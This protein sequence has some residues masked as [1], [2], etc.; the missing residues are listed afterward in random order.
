MTRNRNNTRPPAFLCLCASVVQICLA[1]LTWEAPIIYAMIEILLDLPSVGVLVVPCFHHRRVGRQFER[2]HRSVPYEK[3]LLWPNALRQL[4][5][6]PSTG[7][8]IYLSS[9]IL[10]AR[11]LPDMRTVVLNH[12]ICCRVGDGTGV[13]RVI[14][15]GSGRKRPPLARTICGALDDSQRRR[16]RLR[17]ACAL[18]VLIVASVCVCPEPRIPLSLTMTAQSSA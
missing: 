7:T 1:P 12:C 2:L 9:A 13:C 3:S 16:A 11:P 14:L 17:V 5:T 8:I 15:A 10:A 18:V 6:S 4:S